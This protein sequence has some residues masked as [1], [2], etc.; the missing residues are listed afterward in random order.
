MSNK[1]QET[2]VFISY[3]R[4]DL[5]IAIRLSEDLKK[6][7]L[8]PWLDKY[9]ILPGQ[10]WENE[11]EDAISKSR[12]FIALFSKTSV[13][14]IGYVQ[15]EFQ[16]ALEVFKRYPRNMI[17]YIPVRLDGCDIPYKEL[18]SIHRAD[19]FPVHEDNSWKEGVKQILRAMGITFEY[20]KTKSSQ[21]ISKNELLLKENILKGNKHFY[22]KEYSEAIKCYDKAIELD[23]SNFDAWYSKGNVLGELGS[24]VEA[25]DCYDKAIEIDPSNAY[26]WDNKGW[27]LGE[28]GM[29]NEVI[30]YTNKAIELDPNYALGWDRKGYFLHQ[31]GEYEEAVK[32][33]NRCIELDPHYA[34]VY[35]NK[36]NALTELKEYEEAIKSYDNAIEIDANYADAWNHKGKALQKMGRQKDAK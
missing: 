8:T 1:G 15:N 24:Y 10:N 22:K 3:A 17:F 5:N 14:K 2:I 27:A 33:Y 23:P 34:K 20:D 6:A 31:L 32:C 21:Q 11:I 35:D 9:E 18:N 13:Q 7:G 12:Y 28:L 30:V 29:Y 19:L 26:G 25:I 36:G 4:E 16:W